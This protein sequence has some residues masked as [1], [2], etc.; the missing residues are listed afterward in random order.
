MAC[1]GGGAPGFAPCSIWTDVAHGDDPFV[2]FTLAADLGDVVEMV[3]IAGRLERSVALAPA[4]WML[5][6]LDPPGVAGE[7]A[8]LALVTSGGDPGWPHRSRREDLPV[9]GA[10][11][12]GTPVRIKIRPGAYRIRFEVKESH[13]TSPDLAVR[14]LDIV[15]PQGGEAAIRLDLDR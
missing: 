12:S 7:H 3:D 1:E 15:V 10:Q 5:V 4:S 13:A 11:F 6:D 8:I 9:A 14:E 2:R